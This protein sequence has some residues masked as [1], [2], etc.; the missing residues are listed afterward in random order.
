MYFIDAGC[1]HGSVMLAAG[2]SGLFHSVAG[3]DIMENTPPSRRSRVGR[4]KVRELEISYVVRMSALHLDLGIPK[5]GTAIKD[6]EIDPNGH[7]IAAFSFAQGWSRKDLKTLAAWFVSVEG[8]VLCI[9]G[10]KQG[11]AAVASDDMIYN[12]WTPLL[13]GYKLKRKFEWKMAG[14]GGAMTGLIFAKDRFSVSS[15][16]TLSSKTRKRKHMY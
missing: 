13:T 4:E 2:Y 6:F 7:P 5:Y 10:H 15:T 16:L 3:C 11:R 1:A 8:E 14:G 12:F 9:C